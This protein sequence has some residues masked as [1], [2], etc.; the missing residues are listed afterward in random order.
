MGELQCNALEQLFEG[1]AQ[2]GIV[3]LAAGTWGELWGASIVA[4][5]LN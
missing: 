4:S 5:T 2:D 1:M 3:C